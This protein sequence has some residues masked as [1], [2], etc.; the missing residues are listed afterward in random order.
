MFDKGRVRFGDVWMAS[1]SRI[2]A[3]GQI[4]SVAYHLPNTSI[5]QKNET[6]I[7]VSVNVWSY[8]HVLRTCVVYSLLH[9][10]CFG[11]FSRICHRLWTTDQ[12][13]FLKNI[14][15]MKINWKSSK[16]C[17]FISHTLFDAVNTRVDDNKHRSLIAQRSPNIAWFTICRKRMSGIFGISDWN[18]S[19][20]F[21]L[22]DQS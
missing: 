16:V 10:F 15:H 19:W 18:I 14:M 11:I 13:N 12:V 20:L 3:K 2:F 22:T 7:R 4:R 21:L 5:S 8:K 6:C 9:K 17:L 1:I